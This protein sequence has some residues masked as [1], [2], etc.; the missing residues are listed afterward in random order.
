[1]GEVASKGGGTVNDL[2]PSVAD[3]RRA[4]HG[5]RWPEVII[6]SLVSGVAGMVAGAAVSLVVS[7]TARAAVWCAVAGAT[8][9]GA[10]L[11]HDTAPV[12]AL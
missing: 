9:V 11:A 3:D 6:Y 7:G 4:L 2:L 1:M 8:S 5:R 12:N 10:G